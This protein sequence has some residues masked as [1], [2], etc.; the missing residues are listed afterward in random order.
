MLVWGGGHGIGFDEDNSGLLNNFV[1]AIPTIHHDDDPIDLYSD[2]GIVFTP[3]VTSTS[4]GGITHYEWELSGTDAGFV[5]IIQQSSTLEFTVPTNATYNVDFLLNVTDADSSIDHHYSFYL[6]PSPTITITGG[7]T[8]R[9]VAINQTFTV[10]EATCA[11][12]VESNFTTEWHPLTINTTLAKLHTITYTCTYPGWGYPPVTETLQVRVGNPEPTGP[13]N[14]TATSPHTSVNE[15]QTIQLNGLV[16]GGDHSPLTHNWSSNPDTAGVFSSTDIPNPTFTAPEV[17]RDTIYTLTL[18]VSD[19][20]YSDSDSVSITVLNDPT[21]VVNIPGPNPL[22]IEYNG[23]Y[24]APAVTCTDNDTNNITPVPDITTIDTSAPGDTIVTFTCTDSK[25]QEG[26]ATLTVRVLQPENAPTVTIEGP[27]PLEIEYR[28]TYTAPAVTC[29]DHNGASLTSITSTGTP[30]TSIPA[31]EGGVQ[32]VTFTC[33]DSNG[34]GSATLRVI[35]GERPPTLD[36]LDSSPT[37]ERAEV[38]DPSTVVTCSD[39]FSSNIRVT[40]QGINTRVEGAYPVTFTCTGPTTGLT[41]ERIVDVTVSDTAPPE[42][43]SSKYTPSTGSYSS[44]LTK[45][46]LPLPIPLVL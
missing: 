12:N 6:T 36:V 23:T 19:D 20:T 40:Y 8:L 11:S 14:V 44:H 7:N 33:T 15:G 41:S 13:L 46:L 45:I 42:F 21:P 16:N 18:S 30:D 29:V 26:T 37:L 4:L 35:I 34:P 10:P 27:N 31:S 1:F 32:T 17:D 2:N 5:T 25:S 3:N 24:T 43:L 9:Q 39:D 22:E 28:G 38:F